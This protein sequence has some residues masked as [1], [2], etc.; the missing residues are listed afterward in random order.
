MNK[1]EFKLS[2]KQPKCP[3]SIRGIPRVLW[4]AGRNE[5][6]KAHQLVQDIQSND[7]AWVHAHLHRQEGDNWNADYWYKRAGKTRPQSSI[8]EEWEK[9]VEILL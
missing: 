2:L 7:A 4:L 8:K 1:E 9:L 5:W 6:E 3:E